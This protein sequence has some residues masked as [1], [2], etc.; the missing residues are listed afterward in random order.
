MEIKLI[1]FS[2]KRCS[3][4]E[5][6]KP[7]LKEIAQK[8][9]IPFSEVSLDENPE[10]VSKRLILSAPV[11]LLEMGGKEINRWAGVFSVA[12]IEEFLR[13]IL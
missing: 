8:F 12:Q 13:R 3:V 2:S 1:L 7:K 6:L 10:E 5:S 9:N 11:V 4:C